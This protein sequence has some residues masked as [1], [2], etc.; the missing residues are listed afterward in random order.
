M[1][2]QKLWQE[3]LPEEEAAALIEKIS[4][5]IVDQRMTTPAILALE[6]HKP[7]SNVVAHIAVGGV[8]FIAPVIGI[9]LFNNLTR[10]L[11]K[12]ENVD[13]LILAIEA[14]AGEVRSN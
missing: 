5:K 11:S 7:L 6:M 13:R 12:R 4:T 10:L 8:A 3:E 14:K 9:E 1:V 2:T